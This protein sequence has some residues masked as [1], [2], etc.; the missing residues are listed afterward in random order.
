MVDFSTKSRFINYSYTPM[1]DVRYGISKVT[2]LP[3]KEI[4]PTVKNAWD[5]TKFKIH[6]TTEDR[7]RVVEDESGNLIVRGVVYVDKN[8]KGKVDE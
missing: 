7:S 2:V 3:G 5:L 1:P 4:K 6:A 8:Y